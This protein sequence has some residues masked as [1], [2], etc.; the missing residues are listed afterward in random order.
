M[1]LLFLALQRPSDF[2]IRCSMKSSCGRS[3][4]SHSSVKNYTNYNSY[5]ISSIVPNC[6][7]CLRTN[8]N[9][10]NM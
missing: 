7:T 5:W 10:K 4:D 6:P 1:V 3:H 9:R 2:S 8:L